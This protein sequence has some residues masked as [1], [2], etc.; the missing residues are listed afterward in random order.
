MGTN[1]R[2]ARALGSSLL[3]SESTVKHLYLQGPTPS[4]THGS[5]QRLALYLGLGTVKSVRSWLDSDQFR[6]IFDQ[7]YV[8]VILPRSIHL[9]GRQGP[10][11]G[12]IQ[13]VLREGEV[14]GD[15][16]YSGLNVDTSEFED[17]DHYA[18]CLWQLRYLASNSREGIFRRKNMSDEMMEARLWQ[19]MLR[20]SLERSKAKVMAK[21]R[22]STG[23]AKL[24]AS[25]FAD[26]KQKNRH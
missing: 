23:E 9:P 20:A 7:L 2:R 24:P 10:Q 22:S 12:T 25:I 21:K 4:N 6:P 3:T 18:L 1:P 15:M 19:A 16:R 14:Y 11:L 8:A 5:L 26:D 17:V 13:E